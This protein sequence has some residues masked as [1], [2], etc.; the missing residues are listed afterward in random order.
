[1]ITHAPIGYRCPFCSLAAGVAC[2]GLLS[3]PDDIV[4]RDDRAMAFIASHWRERNQGHVIIAPIRHFENLYELPDDVGAAI[5][6]MS[7]RIAL[8]LK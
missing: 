4:C 8:A 7:R 5:F 2:E 3:M 6:A 1:M